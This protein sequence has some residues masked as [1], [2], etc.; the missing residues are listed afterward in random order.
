LECRPEVLLQAV[1]TFQEGKLSCTQFLINVMI[2][3]ENKKDFEESR[4]RKMQVNKVGL[5]VSENFPV[6]PVKQC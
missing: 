1:A 3:H 2:D 6:S 5:S 4:F